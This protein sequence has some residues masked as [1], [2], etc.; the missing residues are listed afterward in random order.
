MN[1]F[2]INHS[3]IVNGKTEV[4]YTLYDG[5]VTTEDEINPDTREAEPV[6]R[7]RRTAVNGTHTVTLD[8]E[9]TPDQINTALTDNLSSD[10]DLYPID[11]D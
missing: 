4:S 6:T 3:K 11:N 2:K 7:Y 10:H 9:L 8:G 1:Y 5:D